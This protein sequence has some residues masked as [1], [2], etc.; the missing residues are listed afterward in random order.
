[1]KRPALLLI[2]LTAPATA[3]AD[4]DLNSFTE[5]LTDILVVVSFFGSIAVIVGIMAYAGFRARKLRHETIRLPL[6]RGQPMPA[7]LLSGREE[8]TGARDLRR[9]LLLLATGLGLALFLWF[10]PYPGVNWSVGFI[11]GLMGLAYLVAWLVTGRRWTA[12]AS[13]GRAGGT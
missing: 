5:A 8:P 1:M 9:G 4:Q 3:L 10:H 7:E 2:T 12:S 13:D 6:E 11:P